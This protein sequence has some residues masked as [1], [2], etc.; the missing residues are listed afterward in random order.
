MINAS[1]QNP[2]FEPTRRVYQQDQPQNLA[3]PHPSQMTQLIGF[4]SNLAPWHAGQIAQSTPPCTPSTSEQTGPNHQPPNQEFARISVLQRAECQFTV[5]SQ[6]MA[7]FPIAHPSVLSTAPRCTPTKS[8]VAQV[9]PTSSLQASVAN[10]QAEQ[11]FH[12]HQLLDFMTSTT[13]LL[14]QGMCD[15]SPDSPQE[16]QSQGSGDSQGDTGEQESQDSQGSQGSQGSHDFQGSSQGSQWSQGYESSQV[17]QQSKRSKGSKG[18]KISSRS[19]RAYTGRAEAVTNRA[20]HRS[21]MTLEPM[22]NLIGPLLNSLGAASA[23][24]ELT[25][26]G[27]QTASFQNGT[28]DDA[29]HHSETLPYPECKMEEAVNY[30]NSHST[31]KPL[32]KAL[33]AAF[34]CLTRPDS[35]TAANGDSNESGDSPAEWKEETGS[36]SGY[37]SSGSGSSKRSQESGRYGW[38]G[39]FIG[40]FSCWGLS[41]WL[42]EAVYKLNYEQPSPIQSEVMPCILQRHNVVVSELHPCTGKTS[43]CVIA[44]MQLVNWNEN[45]PQALLLAS[46][47]ELAQYT[48]QLVLKLGESAC[49]GRGARERCCLLV[50]KTRVR[51]SV[52][53]FENGGKAVVVATTGRLYDLIRRGVL[54][55]DTVTLTIL[56]EADAILQHL[57]IPKLVAMLPEKMNWAVLCARR[58]PHVESFVAKHM[59]DVKY[60]EAGSLVAP[61]IEHLVVSVADLDEKVNLVDKICDAVL[62]GRVLIFCSVASRKALDQH[63]KEKYVPVDTHREN[64][65]EY[66]APTVSIFIA[67]DA[68]ARGV[69]MSNVAVVINLGLP[70]NSITYAQRAG[71]CCALNQMAHVVVVN[72]L[73]RE[74]MGTVSEVEKFCGIQMMSVKWE[75]ALL[76]CTLACNVPE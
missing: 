71:R 38:N 75:R 72:I 56:D 15:T 3:P 32:D 61:D 24:R 2:N 40:A 20:A 45:V 1:L 44:A 57:L 26:D 14:P 39:H 23:Q 76:Q 33:V 67:S 46:T 7:S 58:T 73:E 31:E 35:P 29:V 74:E 54:R 49:S 6:Q 62:S 42:T 11:T 8:A 37:W 48:H 18:L 52:K 64:V 4:S 13:P 55:T 66:S 30:S 68:L 53:S 28:E 59:K 51:D 10:A 63:L 36:D 5:S 47:R 12:Q 25:G 21:N 16:S 41:S 43:A 27:V 17:S 70:P 60:I 34:A 50:G 65:T 22:H 69:S 9:V 19:L